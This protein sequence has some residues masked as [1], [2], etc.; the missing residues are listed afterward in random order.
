MALRR[1]GDGWRCDC[2]ASAGPGPALGERGRRNLPRGSAPSTARPAAARC[3]AASRGS[4]AG[5]LSRLSS[6]GTARPS[7][8]GCAPGSA[9]GCAP[10]RTV[11]AGSSAIEAPR[12]RKRLSVASSSSISATTMSPV[13]AAS[14][15][16]ISTV[17]PSRMPASIIELPRTSSAKCSPVA[18][19]VG[20]HV[21]DVAPALDRLDRRAGG[22][23]AHDRHGD[24]P[25][26][27]VLARLA[28]RGR[29]CP[30][31]RSA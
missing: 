31:S 20:R 17:S 6:A 1:S 23:A 13:S 16:L 27:V 22:D 9:A 12:R 15:F 4:G 18:Q 24:R 29:D 14:V 28:R 10:R 25:A 30:R 19:H 3:D 8:P 26:A 5:R 2:G 21:D 7:C 11:L